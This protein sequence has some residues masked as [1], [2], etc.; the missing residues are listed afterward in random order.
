MSAREGENHI[1]NQQQRVTLMGTWNQMEAN[2]QE[3][4][5]EEILHGASTEEN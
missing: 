2:E 1:T 3:E 5:E 4:Q